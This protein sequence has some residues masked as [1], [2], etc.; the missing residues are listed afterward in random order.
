MRVGSE[1][2][3]S[4]K[5]TN[6]EHSQSEKIGSNDDLS[7]ELV[8]LLGNSLPVLNL[9]VDV[10]VLEHS[11]AEVLSDSRVSEELG[12]GSDDD[13]ELESFGSGVKDREGLGRLFLRGERTK[14]VS[15]RS[16]LVRA[17]RGESR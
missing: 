16:L 15:S 12:R 4:E 17:E 8:N 5:E 13:V 9:S 10:G 14:A 6:L 1:A 2:R 3:K 11:S 7:S